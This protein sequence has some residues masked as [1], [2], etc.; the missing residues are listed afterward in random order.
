MLDDSTGEK[1]SL[2]SILDLFLESTDRVTDPNFCGEHYT[3]V[4]VLRNLTRK[5]YV[6]SDGIPTIDRHGDNPGLRCENYSGYW[7]VPGLAQALM[8]RVAWSS[9][10]DTGMVLQDRISFHQGA[11]VGDRFDVRLYD[12]VAEDITLDGWADVTL[13]LAKEIFMVWK[14]ECELEEELEEEINDRL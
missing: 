2:P 6:R 3:D 13:E 5:L 7:G 9:C 1:M 8:L 4:W 12:D 11:W 14:S 10:P